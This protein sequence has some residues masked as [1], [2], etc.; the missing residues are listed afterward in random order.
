MI[1]W[2]RA[3]EGLDA[4]ERDCEAL[5]ARLADAPCIDA[6]ASLPGCDLSPPFDRVTVREVLRHRTGLDLAALTERDEHHASAGDRAERYLGHAPVRRDR[7]RR[8]LG[9]PSLDP[10][11][12]PTRAG[13]GGFRPA[14]VDSPRAP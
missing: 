11:V 12:G 1:E 13:R 4:L 14:A 8:P 10:A 5:V 2:Y 7:H 9:R 6:A 3:F